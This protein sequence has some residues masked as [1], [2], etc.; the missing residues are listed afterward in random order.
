MTARPPLHMVAHAQKGV[1]HPVA[2]GVAH[3]G[4]HPKTPAHTPVHMRGFFPPIPPYHVRRGTWAGLRPALA[5]HMA[6]LSTTARAAAK[7]IDLA[8]RPPAEAPRVPLATHGN[9]LVRTLSCPLR[10]RFQ[11]S[12]NK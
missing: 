6:L 4:A 12:V 10:Q 8:S 5:P 3:P 9:G 11:K 2:H 1:A 7:S